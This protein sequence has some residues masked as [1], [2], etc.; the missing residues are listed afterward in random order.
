MGSIPDKEEMA[1][2]TRFGRSHIVIL[3]I[4]GL[5][6]LNAS[7]VIKTAGLIDPLLSKKG[8]NL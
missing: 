5:Y 7:E 2:I 3:P 4:G 6:C 1:S 8:I